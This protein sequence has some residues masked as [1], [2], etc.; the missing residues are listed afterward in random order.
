M[1]EQGC[2]V[3]VASRHLGPVLGPGKPGDCAALQDSRGGWC[4]EYL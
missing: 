1:P 3:L 2:V 4:L